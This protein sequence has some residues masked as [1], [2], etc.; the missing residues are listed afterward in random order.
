MHI[1]VGPPEGDEAYITDDEDM[2]VVKM[3]QCSS[4]RVFR[5]TSQAYT[6]ALS[7]D[8]LEITDE[9]SEEEERIHG[10]ALD[11]TEDSEVEVTDIKVRKDI[12]SS[13]NQ[14]CCSKSLDDENSNSFD[15]FVEHPAPPTI[16]STPEKRAVSEKSKESEKAVFLD[17]MKGYSVKR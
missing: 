7:T 8:V 17:M 16:T 15:I 3:E 11:S 2:F 5:K 6:G 1:D 12:S 10:M 14:G 9:S 13:S 4:R